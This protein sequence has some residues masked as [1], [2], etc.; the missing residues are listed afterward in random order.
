MPRLLLFA[1]VAIALSSSA[2]S[3]EK[4][5]SSPVKIDNLQSQPPAD[6]KSEKPANR[7]RA[8]QFRLPKTKD[9]KEDAELAILPNVT[10]TNESNIARW[11]DM[12]L[13]PDGKTIDE[14]SKVTSAKVGAAK[15]TTLE[16]SGT[17][18]YKDRPLSAKV[19]VPKANY[20]MLS[21]I[22]ETAEGPTLIRVIGPVTTLEHHRPGFESFLKSFK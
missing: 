6:W 19:P 12:F 15:L 10:G 11:K 17:Y 22:F 8:Y 21:V 14:V 16:V 5:D 7:L 13:P 20:R 2:H 9:D 18:L 1:F 3:G 4:K